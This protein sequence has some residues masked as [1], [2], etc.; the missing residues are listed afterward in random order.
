MLYEVITIAQIIEDT[1]TKVL[2]FYVNQDEGDGPLK[3]TIKLNREDITPVLRAFDRYE[4][5]V[6]ASYSEHSTVDEVV[7]KNFV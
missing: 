2:S 5:T 6:T 7:K 1:D 3:I 4:Y